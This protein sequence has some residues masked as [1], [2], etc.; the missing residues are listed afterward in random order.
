MKNSEIIKYNLFS[1]KIKKDNPIMTICTSA[2]K[3][4]YFVRIFKAGNRYILDMG[5]IEFSLKITLYSIVEL[6]IGNNSIKVPGRLTG[7]VKN[8]IQ[9][10]PFHLQ[11]S[12]TYPI[13]YTRHSWSIPMIWLRLLLFHDGIS[14]LV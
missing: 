13:F 1:I 7:T 6:G 14:W 4:I 9:T 10:H 2:M 8:S 5:W 12:G 3:R 11:E